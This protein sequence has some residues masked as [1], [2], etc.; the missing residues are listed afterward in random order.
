VCLR[1][2]RAGASLFAARRVECKMRSFIFKVYTDIIRRHYAPRLGVAQKRLAWNAVVLRK[3]LFPISNIKKTDALL[4]PESVAIIHFND[5][6][7]SR[8]RFFESDTFSFIHSSPE[9]FVVCQ[10]WG[11]DCV[12]A[13]RDMTRAGANFFANT[14]AFKIY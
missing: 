6:S 1:R 14:S 9:Q 11:P 8:D 12:T 13:K 10:G 3:C 5:S 7:R 4:D 2:R